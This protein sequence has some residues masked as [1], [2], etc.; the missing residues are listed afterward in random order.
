MELCQQVNTRLKTANLEPDEY[1]FNVSSSAR[2]D[3]W[4]TEPIPEYWRFACFAVTGASEGYYVHVAV[5]L[6][7][8]GYDPCVCGHAVI[9]HESARPDGFGFDRHGCRGAYDQ[10]TFKYVPCD[11]SKYRPLRFNAGHHVSLLLAKC[12]SMDL[13]LQIAGACTRMRA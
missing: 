6:P 7:S 4:D 12:W 3:G 1:G 5:I 10:T 11:C 8:K 2:H 9:D 13:A